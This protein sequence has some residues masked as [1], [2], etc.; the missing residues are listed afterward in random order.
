MDLGFA[1]RAASR[2][3]A[4]DVLEDALEVVRMLNENGLFVTLDHL[5][6]N[7]TSSKEAESATGDYL[8]ILDRIVEAGAK[9]NI[10]VKLTQLGLNIRLEDCLDNMHRI[11]RRAETSGIMVRIDIEDSK[12]VDRTWHTFR[13]LRAEGLTNIGLA[14]QSYLYRSQEDAQALLA[15][16]AHFRLCKG[17]YQEPAQVAFPH[18]ADVDSNFDNLTA[19]I[20]GS[21]LATGSAPSATNGRFPPVAAIATHDQKRIAFAREYADQIGLPKH[22]LEFQMLYGIRSDLQKLL[23]DEGYPVRIYVPFGTEWYPYLMR[24]LAERPANVWFFLSNLL[25][26]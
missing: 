7:V 21:A 10:S 6:E 16:G 26:N 8:E 23:S 5:G 2:F 19:I 3:V 9:S 1:R 4:G 14:I 25:R 20:I 12:T 24:R 18:K 13:T 15:E 11:A 17:A 22:A